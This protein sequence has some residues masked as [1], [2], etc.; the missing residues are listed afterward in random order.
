MT[1]Q[2]RIS[3]I[4]RRLGEQPIDPAP[5]ESL[6]ESGLIDSFSLA[7]LVAELETEFHI[8]IPDS[9]LEP[10]KF[11]TIARIEAYLKSLS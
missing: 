10:R 5:D 2:E 4:V 1:T 9:D 8:H 11:D 6:F 7:D 3:A